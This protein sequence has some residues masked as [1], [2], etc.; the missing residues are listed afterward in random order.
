MDKRN[1]RPVWYLLTLHWVSVVGTALVTTA[2]LSFLFALPHQI[3]G[4]VNNPYIGIIIFR[5]LPV[6]FFAGLTL[7]PIGIYLGK[8]RLQ[9]AL[10]LQEPDRKTVIRRLAWFF[11]VTTIL[12][13]YDRN[14]FPELSVKWGTYPNSLCH[15]DFPVA[16]DATTVLTQ[17][18]EGGR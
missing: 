3:R 8:R 17:K 15:T 9:K 2:V 10:V 7:I 5:I 12:N 1:R 18:R 13:I 14:V 16:S 11:G 4:H 6:I